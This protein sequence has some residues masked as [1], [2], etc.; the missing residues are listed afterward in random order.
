[1]GKPAEIFS[2]KP[3]FVKAELLSAVLRRIIELTI[4]FGWFFLLLFLLLFLNMRLWY[5]YFRKK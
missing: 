2:Y 4:L 5:N 3:E 1:M